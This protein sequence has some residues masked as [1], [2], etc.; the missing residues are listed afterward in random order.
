MN[1]PAPLP[2]APRVRFPLSFKLMIFAAALLVASIVG[3]GLGAMALTSDTVQTS[4]RELQIA[5]LQDVA[6]GIT[7]EFTHAQDDLDALGRTLTD[8]AVDE[9]A[10][11]DTAVHLVESSEVLDVVAI[12]DA[13]GEAITPIREHTAQTVATP[14]QLDAAL[15]ERAAA[16]NLAIGEVERSA[17]GPR[18]PVVVP[19]RADERVTGYALALLATNAIATR[20]EG[21]AE[22]HFTDVPGGLF[23]VDAGRRVIAHPDRELVD[24]L[25]QLP[26]T[27]ILDGFDRI[28]LPSRFSRASEF[29]D[30]RGVAM[31]GTLVALEDRPWVVAAQTPRELAYAPVER[32]RNIVLITIAGAVLA[33]I[34]ASVVLARRVTSPLE[35][36]SA[37]AGAIARRE[38]DS[39]IDIRTDDEVGLLARAM[40]RAAD[41][42]RVGEQRLAREHAIRSDLGRY[43][44]AE[45][46]D[47][48]VRREQDMALGGQRLELS[49]MFADVVAFTPLTEKLPPERVVQLLNELFTIVTEIVFRHGGTI[50][51]FVG[52]CV[53][54]LWGAPT[55]QPDHAARAAAAAEEI[56]SWL[57]AGNAGWQQKYGVQIQLAIGINSGEAVVGNIG[58]E[59]R[60][61]YTAI[62][63]VVNVAARLE[64]IAR[65]GQVLVTAATRERAGAR[66]RFE[67]LGP[68][69]I[70]G[71]AEPLVLFQLIP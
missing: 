19:L 53:M 22:T 54:A 59:R 69:P 48:V 67:E 15:R 63:D 65:P 38:F 50:D 1:P 17:S 30:D 25:A 70:A 2:P 31:V 56:L 58:S 71:R 24:S 12:Y 27:G 20:V 5:I 23:V 9:D 60:M 13:R 47:K 37:Y 41:D 34:A 18:V 33:A 40:V 3:V 62:G 35:Q 4:Q 52:D 7:A 26:A 64:A 57:E 46:V 21:L 39:Q 29:T 32:M 8:A 49:V 51:K 44:P 14:A 66:F 28:A 16:E 45:L 42:L 43:L 10:R 68:R 11:I 55:P 61:E 6:H 36:L